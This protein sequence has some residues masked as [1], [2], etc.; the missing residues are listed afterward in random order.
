MFFTDVV[1][2]K[3]NLVGPLN[4]GWTIAKRLLQ[5]ERKGLAAAAQAQRSDTRANVPALAR[6]YVGVDTAGRIADPDLRA[7]I[8]QFEIGLRC[9]QLTNAR[10]AAE[11][12]HRAGVNAASS[13]LKQIGS[14][15]RRDGAELIVEVMGAQGLGWEGEAFSA[16]EIAHI[17][18]LYYSKAGGI[19]GGSQEIQYNIIAKRI[20]GLPD[21]T[22]AT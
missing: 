19:A 1:T 8:T 21:P 16:E 7:R 11:S 22:S 12:A 18:N 9:F 4:G 20:L 5:H 10:V 2:P 14:F 17:R 15:L 13:T 3:E 6:H